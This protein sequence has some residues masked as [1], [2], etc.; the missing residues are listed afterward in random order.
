MNHPS[1][2]EGII[3]CGYI[4]GEVIIENDYGVL[5]VGCVGS[6]DNC[7]LSTVDEIEEQNV[8]TDQPEA[9]IRIETVSDHDYCEAQVN[10]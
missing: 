5:D 8:N 6:L 9:D 10:D 4:C 2:F 7:E 1:K 3:Y